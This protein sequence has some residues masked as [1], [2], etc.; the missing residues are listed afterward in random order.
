MVDS[1]NP[2]SRAYDGQYVLAGY[3]GHGMPRAF[4]WYVELSLEVISCTR[5]T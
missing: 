1:S 3:S 5:L 2:D 4:A